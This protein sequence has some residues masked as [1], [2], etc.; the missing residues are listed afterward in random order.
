MELKEGL[1]TA[2]T[3]LDCDAVAGFALAVT[4]LCQRGGRV[5]PSTEQTCQVTPDFPRNALVLVAIRTDSGH[6]EKLSQYLAI[7]PGCGGHIVT[8]AQIGREVLRNARCC[9]G[10]FRILK[11]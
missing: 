6:C 8:A 7:V 3:C 11:V 1:V 9:R 4:V 2:H 5:M 10:R